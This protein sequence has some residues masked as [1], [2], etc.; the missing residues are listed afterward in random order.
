MTR[1]EI[2]RA[3]RDY[4]CE[5][6]HAKETGRQFPPMEIYPF[7][8]RKPAKPWEN[9]ARALLYTALLVLLVLN[10]YGISLA[11]E[12]PVT[13]YVIVAEESWLNG[14]YEPDASSSIEARFPSGAAVEVY[15]ASGAWAKVAGGECGYVW[16][17][18]N[19]LSS[20]P[21]GSEP[22]TCTVQADGRIRVRKAPGGELV[23]W[24]HAGDTVQVQCRLNGWAFIGDGYVLEKYLEVSP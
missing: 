13:M 7:G 19:Y 10:W 20:T 5:M 2:N 8:P 4:P 6:V 17:A 18:I 14:R 9:I 3:L 12:Q 23:R 22:E 1:R 15:E 16:C 11:E 21:P 24:L